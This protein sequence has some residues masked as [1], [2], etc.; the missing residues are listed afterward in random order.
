MER[1]TAP[2]VLARY[3]E[4]IGRESGARRLELAA[5]LS[6]GT[7]ELAMAGLRQRYPAADAAELR[8]RLAELLYGRAVAE[9]AFG[10]LAQPAMR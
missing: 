10:R 6:E 8:R 4:L 7:R 1:D 3:R 5:G 2:V 9:R